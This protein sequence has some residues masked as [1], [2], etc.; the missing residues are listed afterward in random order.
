L[1]LDLLEAARTLVE[2]GE[3]LGNDVPARGRQIQTGKDQAGA[4]R[5]KKSEQHGELS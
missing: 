5:G 2:R 1:K 3:A 4:G